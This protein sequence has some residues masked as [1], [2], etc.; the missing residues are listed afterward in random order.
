MR[1]KQMVGFVQMFVVFN[2]KF[3]SIG[4]EVLNISASEDKEYYVDKPKSVMITL[5]LEVRQYGEK[6]KTDE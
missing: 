1:Q 5:D 3:E 4:I 2:E 6:I